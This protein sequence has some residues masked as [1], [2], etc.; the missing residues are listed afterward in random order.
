MPS[1]SASTTVTRLP[2]HGALIQVD[3]PGTASRFPARAA[4]V[5][6]P[7]AYLTSQRPR[8][9]VLVLLGGQPG[10]PRDWV[11]G[12]SVARTLDAFAATHRGLA[13]VVVMP[14]A[15]GGETANPLCIDSRLGAADTYLARDVPAWIRSTLHVDPSPTRWAVGGFSYGGTCALQLAVAHPDVFPTFVDV[16]GQRSPTL[17][18]PATTIDRAFGGDAAAFAAGSRDTAA[19]SDAAAV[20]DAL[21]GAGATAAVT[22]LPGGHSW[23]VAGAAL[24]RA[25]PWLAARWGLVP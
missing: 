8:L 3:I 21:T 4:W 6:V 20:R 11:D 1:G 22:V 16:S 5:Y 23:A 18:D 15:L 19:R 25:L 14:D 17:G 2:G 9:P 13:P 24:D 12:G 10:G 7:P